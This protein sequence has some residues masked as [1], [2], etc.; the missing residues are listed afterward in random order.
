MSHM[1]RGDGRTVDLSGARFDGGVAPVKAGRRGPQVDRRMLRGDG[2]PVDDT[3]TVLVRDNAA[4]FA[5]DVETARAA[6]AAPPAISLEQ[7]IERINNE[8][9]T[10]RDAMAIAGTNQRTVYDWIHK[11]RICKE[12]GQ[13]VYLEEFEV[14]G[15]KCFLRENLEA[16]LAA[17]EWKG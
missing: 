3:S 15:R 8:V 5:M 11:G 9:C 10:F 2:E 14:A 17:I 7:A 4:S 12:T 6:Q 1:I 13:K 16:F